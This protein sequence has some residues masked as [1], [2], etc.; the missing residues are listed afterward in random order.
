MI[1]RLI[2]H[3]L[4]RAGYTITHRDE[5]AAQKLRFLSEFKAL[6]TSLPPFSL[7]EKGAS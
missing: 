3:L 2:A 5:V 7:T 4:R 1:G 6:S